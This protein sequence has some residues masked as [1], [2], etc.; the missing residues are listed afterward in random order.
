MTTPR[1]NYILHDLFALQT[2]AC[3]FKVNS[4]QWDK[5]SL[6]MVVYF[7]NQLSKNMCDLL[8]FLITA[9]YQYIQHA[10]CNIY[11]NNWKIF[12]SERKSSSVGQNHFA[13]SFRVLVTS[14]MCKKR[15]ERTK[16]NYQWWFRLLINGF[17]IQFHLLHHVRRP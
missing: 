17:S 15:I 12:W 7:S 16:K 4:F 13:T 14:L 3:N 11:V 2:W 5:N 9:M 8:N 1:M 10:N 6:R